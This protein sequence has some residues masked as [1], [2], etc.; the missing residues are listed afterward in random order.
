[1]EVQVS[2]SK[3][4]AQALKIMRDVE[5]SGDQVIIT[6]H[7]KP[8]LV[9]RKYDASDKSPMELLKGSVINYESPTAQVA[10]DDWELA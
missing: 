9:I 4:K 6:D 3:F 1:M 2:K 10:E 8:T 7:G 5:E